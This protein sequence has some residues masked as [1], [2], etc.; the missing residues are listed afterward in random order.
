MTADNVIKFPT[1]Q[2]IDNVEIADEDDVRIESISIAYQIMDSLHDIIHEETEE[3][4]FTDDEY[5][6]MVIFLSEAISAMYLKASGFDHPM[7]EIAENLFGDVDIDP[8]MEYNESND[9]DNKE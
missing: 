7:Q 3:C 4:I 5:V 9:D 2:L 6:P 8:D 1:K